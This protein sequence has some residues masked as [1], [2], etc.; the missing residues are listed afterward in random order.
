MV[1]LRTKPKTLLAW[2]IQTLTLANAIS[3]LRGLISALMVATIQCE[4]DFGYP[5]TTALWVALMG[6]FAA[7]TDPLDGLIAQWRG[8]TWVGARL[9]QWMDWWL[10]IALL[11]AVAKT[12]GLSP[13]NAPFAVAIFAYLVARVRYP[14]KETSRE[15]K[16]SSALLMTGGATILVGH[17]F[18]LVEITWAGYGGL[19][20]G[21]F[22]TYLAYRSYS[23]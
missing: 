20:V 4:W 5:G 14:T 21:L 8:P 6:S 1:H 2:R 15:A 16:I 10:G 18:N 3:L 13:F 11:F 23:R 12:E 22:F 17:A 7:T 19:T 9:D